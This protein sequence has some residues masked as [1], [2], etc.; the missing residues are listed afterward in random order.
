MSLAESTETGVL[1]VHALLARAFHPRAVTL[2]G[3]TE[4]RHS[5]RQI[6][7]GLTDSACAFAGPINLVSQTAEVVHGRRA[8]RS[9]ADVPSPLG[10]VYLLVPTHKCIEVLGEIER[11]ADRPDGVVVLAAGFREVGNVADE[12]EIADWGRRNE[13]AV[14]GPQAIGIAR[15]PARLFAMSL[16]F[17]EVQV[18][19]GPVAVIAQSGGLLGCIQRALLGRHTGLSLGASIGTQAMIDYIDI[20]TYAIGLP[21]TEVLTIYVDDAG[22]LNRLEQLGAARRAT[23]KHVLMCVGAR[24][25]QTERMAASH[26][27]AISQGWPLISGICEQ[28]GI[29]LAASPDDLVFGAETLAGLRRAGKLGIRHGIGVVASSGGSAMVIAGT[30]ADAGID[31]PDVSAATRDALGI[32]PAAVANPHDMGTSLLGNPAE[33]VNHIRTFAREPQFDVVVSVNPAPNA[34]DRAHFEN[35]KR[36]TAAIEAEGKLPVVAA[37]LVLAGEDARARKLIPGVV[38]ATGSSELTAKLRVLQA[39]AHQNL[40]RDLA[41]GWCPRDSGGS[42]RLADVNGSRVIAGPPATA[43]LADLPVTWPQE[44]VI[45]GE[46]DIDAVLARMSFPVVVKANAGLAH[47][48]RS[49]GVITDIGTAAELLAA[50]EYVRRRFG[51]SALVCEQVDVVHELFL[52]FER[53]AEDLSVIMY[54]RGGSGVSAADVDIRR[55]PLSGLEIADLVSAYPG[56]TRELMDL[57]DMFQRL[58]HAAGRVEAIDLNPIG[59]C[60]DGRLVVLDAKLHVTDGHSAAAGGVEAG[61]R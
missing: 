60:R 31:L 40:A 58:A 28:Q 55:L 24:S 45:G 7:R 25:E 1:D 2:V 10:L 11:H 49:G 47:R 20:A 32:A 13:V 27:G 54:G 53:R 6:I 4:K 29:V 12:L 59:V 15:P 22:D 42:I 5:T 33:Y 38:H 43:A 23:G 50:V 44:S 52:G 56:P 41:D 9:L 30:L 46:T 57:I 48:S 17:A 61:L 3:A 18:T 14:F 35:Y 8:Y 36:F 16:P 21:D 34:D 19:A 37:P 51:G 26:T 39:I